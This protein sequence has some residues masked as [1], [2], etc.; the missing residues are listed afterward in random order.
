MHPEASNVFFFYF[1]KCPLP[2]GKNLPIIKQ[3]STPAHLDAVYEVTLALNSLVN[4]MKQC[5]L[6]ITNANTVEQQLNH[7]TTRFN[8]VHNNLFCPECFFYPVDS[9]SMP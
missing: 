3:I 1:L 9:T 6:N 7:P 8:F 4:I 2:A 5:Q